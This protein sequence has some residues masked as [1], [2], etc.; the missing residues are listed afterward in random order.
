MKT[1]LVS[2]YGVSPAIRV[3]QYAQMN[4]GGVKTPPLSKKNI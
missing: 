2:A 1:N 4:G 3:K